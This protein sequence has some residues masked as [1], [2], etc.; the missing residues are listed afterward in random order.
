MQRLKRDNEAQK[1]D[2]VRKVRE[3]QAKIDNNQD[4]FKQYKIK[5]LK[6][7][8]NNM[9]QLQ[10]D[11]MSMFDKANNAEPIELDVGGLKLTVDK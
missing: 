2:R 9:E 1:I 11:I 4:Q 5:D 6:Q 3:F 8:I 7:E 10:Y